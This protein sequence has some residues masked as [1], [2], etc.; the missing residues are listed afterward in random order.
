MATDGLIGINSIY[1]E[2]IRVRF[3]PIMVLPMMFGFITVPFRRMRSRS[4][5][6]GHTE[7]FLTPSN[8]RTTLISL[9]ASCGDA[10]FRLNFTQPE[11]SN[12]R[13]MTYP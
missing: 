4:S 3:F 9:T 10:S 11:S 2:G 1:T 5:P 12:I 7:G 13:S 8:C 6:I